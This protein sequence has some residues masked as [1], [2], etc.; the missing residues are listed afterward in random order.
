[1]P[2]DISHQ[3]AH[4]VLINRDELVE[5]ARHGSHGKVRGADADVIEFGNAARKNRPLDVAGDRE[6]VF[7]GEQAVLVGEHQPQRDVSK[8]EQKNSETEVVQYARA[9][10]AKGTRQAV[11]QG[12]NGENQRAR[13]QNAAIRQNEILA[14]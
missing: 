8:R 7:N 4:P 6:F 14:G 12:F 3:T 2:A 11:I 1:M 10:V 9:R 13:G 5:V